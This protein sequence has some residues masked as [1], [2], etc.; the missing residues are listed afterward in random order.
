MINIDASGPDLDIVA[1]GKYFLRETIGLPQLLPGVMAYAQDEPVSA[2]AGN[3]HFRISW[4]SGC[5]G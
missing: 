4:A 3:S 2:N 5:P 1:R